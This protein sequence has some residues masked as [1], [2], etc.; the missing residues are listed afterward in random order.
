M[1]SIP[2]APT[3]AQ[4]R[5]QPGA[6]GVPTASEVAKATG[7]GIGGAVLTTIVA[8]NLFGNDPAARFIVAAGATLFGTILAA[9]SPPA[10]IPGEIGMGVGSAGATISALQLADQINPPPTTTGGASKFGAAG[11]IALRTGSGLAGG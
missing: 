8:L 6:L 4:V 11:R 3:L 5:S 9:T 7:F 10:S 1:A 2:V